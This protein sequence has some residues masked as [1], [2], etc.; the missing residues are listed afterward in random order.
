MLGSIG[1]VVLRFISHRQ[2]KCI[3]NQIIKYSVVGSEGGVGETKNP[4]SARKRIPRF[5]KSDHEALAEI[6]KKIGQKELSKVNLLF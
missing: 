1:S 3:T 4:E 5:S 2:A 6:F